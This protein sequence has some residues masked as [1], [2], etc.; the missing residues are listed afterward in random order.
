MNTY[1]DVEV[2][3]PDCMMSTVVHAVQSTCLQYSISSTYYL[4]DMPST[5]LLQLAE[6]IKL[7]IQLVTSAENLYELT[8]V[9]VHHADRP[10][11][12]CVKFCAALCQEA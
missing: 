5:I 8:G 9:E 2:F 12:H 6:G 7:G 11:W 4:V 1:I 10:M 3:C